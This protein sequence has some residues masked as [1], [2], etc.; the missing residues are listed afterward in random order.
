MFVHRF[1]IEAEL[2]RYV[3]PVKTFDGCSL[4]LQALRPL[5][6]RGD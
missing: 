4:P 3:Y 5:A 2:V 1:D 6:V